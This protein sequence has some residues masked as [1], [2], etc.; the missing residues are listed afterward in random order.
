[1][2]AVDRA[3]VA[4][5]LWQQRGAR[6]A[7]AGLALVA[8]VA[9][10]ADCLAADLPLLARHQG[11]LHVLP[12]LLRPA[13]LRRHDNH[14]LR[15]TRG[16]GDWALE[17]PI[18]FGPA[19]T[20]PDG[21]LLPSA[22]PGAGHWLGTDEV[23]RD[24]TAQLVHGCRVALLVGAVAVLLGVL[25]GLILGLVAGFLRGWVDAVITFATGAVLTFPAFLLILAVQGLLGAQSVMGIV[26]IL[27]A[28]GWAGIARLVRAE[29]LRLAA[30]PFVEAARGLGGSTA[31]L[32]LT[33]VLPHVAGPVLVAATFAAGAAILTES[34]L[35]FLGLGPD[36][37][38]WGRLLAQAQLQRSAWWLTVFPG[39]AIFVTVLASNHVAEGLQTAL[40]PRAPLGTGR[41]PRP[42]A[43][44]AVEE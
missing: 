13:A 22:P 42:V 43:G 26:L 18:P 19:Q 9:L 10:T 39:M 28:T 6:A 35:S 29:V 30:E 44:P 12:N 15:R 40:D 3:S 17:P 23:G 14:S 37:P 4:S 36:A 24:V 21:A 7:L 16:A 34:A 38:S 20:Q 27:A 11:E 8:L 32:L 31:R 25:A 5:R 33:H 41:G 1:V 2:S